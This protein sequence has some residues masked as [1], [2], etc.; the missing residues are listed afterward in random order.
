MRRPTCLLGFAAVLFFG[1][2]QLGLAQS[3]LDRGT[4]TVPRSSV[5]VPERPATDLLIFVPEGAPMAQPSPPPGAETPGSLACVYK[6]TKQV[7]GCPIN[8]TT[9]VPIGGA[10]A[11]AVVEVGSDPA[12]QRDL[13]T[14]SETLSLHFMSFQTQK[15]DSI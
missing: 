5:P 3:M 2:T 1:V 8:G 14:Y 12:L 13:D 7:K 11:I 10:N 4:V 15:G 9:E 6:L